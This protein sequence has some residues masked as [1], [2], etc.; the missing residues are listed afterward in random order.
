MMKTPL[1]ALSWFEIPVTDFV[2]AKKFYSTIFNFDMPEMTFGPVRMGF[3]L[4]DREKQGIGGAIVHN[5]DFYEPSANGTKVYLNAA[6]DLAVVLD[7]VKRAGGE[8]V[9]AKKAIGPD[10]GFMGLFKDCEGNVVALH[11]PK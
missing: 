6:P 7:R 11:S 8:V 10:M 4:H 3:F 1:N 2:R 9:I 5:A